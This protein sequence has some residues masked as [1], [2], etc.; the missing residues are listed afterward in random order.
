MWIVRLIGCVLLVAGAALC[1]LLAT[2][3]LSNIWG[4]RDSPTI[5]YVSGASVECAVAALLILGA[6]LM[7]PVKKRRLLVIALLVALPALAPYRLWLPYVGAWW[8]PNVVFAVLAALF[9]VA[10]LLGQTRH[11]PSG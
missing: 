1:V 7:L 8:I 3:A 2:S 4:E 9:A 11:E 5:A 10:G 6:V